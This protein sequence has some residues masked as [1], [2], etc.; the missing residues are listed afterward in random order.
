MTNETNNINIA[1]TDLETNVSASNAGTVLVNDEV[2]KRERPESITDEMEKAI[3]QYRVDYTAAV[4]TKVGK[5]AID[6]MFVENEDCN[7]VVSKSNM[8]AGEHKVVVTTNRV[9]TV[10]RGGV[11]VKVH[12]RTMTTVFTP[13]QSKSGP[14]K[15]ALD[16]L[17]ERAKFNQK[18]RE[19]AAAAKAK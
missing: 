3:D 18:Q 2:Y 7:K 5:V 1:D 4:I 12:G 13:F 10:K 19:E 16:A 11:G 6:K 14:I 8:G 17:T 15:S 9:A